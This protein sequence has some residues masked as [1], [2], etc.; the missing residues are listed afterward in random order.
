[1][2]MVIFVVSHFPW[3]VTTLY[4]F[5][6]AAY[7]INDDVKMATNLYMYALVDCIYTYM[8]YAVRIFNSAHFKII[9]RTIVVNKLTNILAGTHSCRMFIQLW[10]VWLLL[11][12]PM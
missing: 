9:A 7:C 3:K 5:R 1:M 2:L 11:L 12:L 10:S 4:A 8:L 6:N